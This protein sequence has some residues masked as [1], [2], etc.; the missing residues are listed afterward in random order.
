MKFVKNYG[1]SLE[2]IVIKERL[3][4]IFKLI[5]EIE[6]MNFEI[7]YLD[8]YMGFLFFSIVLF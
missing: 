2:I 6:I 8:E 3:D 4:E 5:L 1:F 7:Y